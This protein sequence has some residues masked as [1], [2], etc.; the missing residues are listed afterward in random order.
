MSNSSI[1][2]MDRTLSGSTIP[3]Q[4]AAGSNGNEEELCFPQISRISVASS[5]CLVSY[6]GHVRGCL[7]SLQRCSQCILQTQPSGLV[8]EKKNG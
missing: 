1:K 6:P 7:T 2:L 8:F 3:G 4:S 5:D